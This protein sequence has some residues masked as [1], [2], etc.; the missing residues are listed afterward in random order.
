[1]MEPP[2]KKGEGRLVID[3]NE[4]K[5]Y[6]PSPWEAAVNL[7]VVK[8]PGVDPKKT[9]THN[10][11]AV[12]DQS[13]K[14]R[15]ELDK[16]AAK[17]GPM[18]VTTLRG[19]L[20]DLVGDLS[21][22]T[23]LTGDAAKIGESIYKKADELL[24]AGDGSVSSVLQARRDLD[25]WVRGQKNVFD[26]SFENATTVALKEIRDHM[27]KSVSKAVGN[28]K[29][30]D[31]LQKQNK[32][33]FAGDRLEAHALKE[34]DGKIGRLI[35]K[36]EK[37]TGEKIPTTPLAQWATGAYAVG[38]WAMWVPLIPLVGGWKGVKWLATPEGKQALRKAA[39]AAKDQPLVQP[40]INA[41]IQAA[42]GLGAPEEE[43]Y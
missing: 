1:M 41:L 21:E 12:R 28:G 25:A 26:S 9:Y 6:E 3:K 32:L 2:G 31:L 36:M 10:M 4:R 7:E 19:E 38:K 16:L 11:N 35:Q 34:A 15:N 40:E 22:R 37:S 29:V 13:T 42:E 33:L 8:T 5:V 17:A 27:N 24:A 14:Y 43:D 20:S 18:D 30:D 23:L 39:R